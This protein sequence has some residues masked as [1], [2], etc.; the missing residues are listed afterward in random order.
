VTLEPHSCWLSHIQL[1]D[2]VFQLKSKPWWLNDTGKEA[3]AQSSLFSSCVHWGLF[4][5]FAVFLLCGMYFL[6]REGKSIDRLE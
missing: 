2:R 5:G 1:Y 4:R 3:G 6:L